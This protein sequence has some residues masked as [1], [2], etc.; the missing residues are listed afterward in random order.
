MSTSSAPARELPVMDDA[1]PS[2]KLL[3]TLTIAG[4]VAGL[5][6]VFL[7]DATLPRIEAYKA[8]VLRAAVAEVLHAPARADTLWLANGA[9]TST[10][11]AEEQARRAERVYLGFDAAGRPSGYAL[12]VAEPG[13]S[14]QMHL[15]I[16]YDPAKHELLGMKVLESKETPGIADDVQRPVFT[17][18]F[19]G[20][21]AP[22]VGIKAADRAR[23]ASERSAV[24]M[25]TGATISSRA[26]LRGINR[27]IEHWQPYL[28]AYRPRESTA[29]ATGGKN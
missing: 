4:A 16:G 1:V 28:E 17:G 24:V 25:I 11:P 7:Y 10:R 26:V 9:L 21:I 2:W 20:R 22:L 18:Q 8:G 3:T 29:P 5:A 27:T 12:S 19:A 14:E 13:F 23:A 15:L 6:V